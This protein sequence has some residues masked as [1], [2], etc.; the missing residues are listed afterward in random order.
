[1]IAALVR[2][3]HPSLISFRFANHVGS[4]PEVVEGGTYVAV[5]PARNV[6]ALLRIP[7]VAA[8]AAVPGG[9]P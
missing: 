4:M 5:D 1:M 3:T 8:V 6:A 9:Q 7:E 2:S